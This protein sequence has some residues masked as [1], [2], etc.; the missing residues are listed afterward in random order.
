MVANDSQS[1]ESEADREHC[2]SKYGISIELVANFN[3][4]FSQF[5]SLT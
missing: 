4:I 3:E 2:N 5:V 1:S